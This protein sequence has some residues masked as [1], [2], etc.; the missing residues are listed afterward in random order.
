M[1]ES[2]K[3]LR[4]SSNDPAYCRGLSRK[5]YNVAMQM[6][7]RNLVTDKELV[8]AGKMLP[9]GPKG[10]PVSEAFKWFMEVKQKGE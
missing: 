8:E 5:D 9:P 2:K 7:K 1:N 6:I 10:R 4:P 3:S